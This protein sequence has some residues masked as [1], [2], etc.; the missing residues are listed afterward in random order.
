MMFD[1]L[2][3]EDTKHPG[4]YFSFSEWW[5]IHIISYGDKS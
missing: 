1:W 3:K 2:K 4:F 5:G